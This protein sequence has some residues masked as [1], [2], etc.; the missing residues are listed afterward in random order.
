MTMIC[1]YMSSTMSVVGR[2][3]QI[4]TCPSAGGSS[5]SG[6]QLIS[7]DSSGVVQVWQTP[8]RQLHRLGTSQASARSSTL[9]RS[10]PNGAV[11]PLRA[12]VTAGP[13]WGGLGGRCGG[14][15]V[16]PVM[17]GLTAGSCRRRYRG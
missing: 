17:P 11:I 14:L 8:V 6:W 9:C 1:L 5:G 7:P 10:P 16:C 4:S 12:K 13:A 3:Q 2:A 15:R